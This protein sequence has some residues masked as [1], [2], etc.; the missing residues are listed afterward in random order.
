MGSEWRDNRDPDL[1]GPAAPTGPEPFGG[2]S[3]RHVGSSYVT[4]CRSASVLETWPSG[5]P[6]PQTPLDGQVSLAS[7]GNLSA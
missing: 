5:Q 4:H 7:A 1:E 2:I 3:E 6:E